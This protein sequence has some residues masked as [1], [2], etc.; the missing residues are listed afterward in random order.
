MAKPAM[1]EKRG[2][3]YLFTGFF[4][5]LLLGL[6]Y[7][8]FINPVT[9]QDIS[10]ADLKENQ[11]YQYRLMIVRAYAYDQDVE[12]ALARLKLLKDDS[13]LGSL[14]EMRDDFEKSPA[15]PRDLQA[16]QALLLAFGQTPVNA[17]EKDLVSAT[18]P[19]GVLSTPTLVLHRSAT[20]TPGT[21]EPGRTALPATTPIVLL[22]PSPTTAASYRYSEKNYVCDPNL[23]EKLLQVQVYTRSGEPVPGAKVTVS[24]EEGK[25]SVFYTGFYPDMGPGYADFMMSQGHSYTVTVGD[26]DSKISGLLVTSCRKADGA[27]YFGSVLVKF[28]QQ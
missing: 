20:L 24:W 28:I 5:G 21:P 16:V 26:S 11:Q 1:N 6:G 27:S 25:E 19:L 15:D 18:D 14:N 13:V 22:T 10:P 2:I 4:L 9:F 12:R 17:G 3:G 23:P 8:W 7:A